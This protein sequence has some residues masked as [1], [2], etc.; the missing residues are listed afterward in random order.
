MSSY[1]RGKNGAVLGYTA[2]FAMIPELKLS[3]SVARSDGS[4]G[5]S[6]GVAF[7][8]V[9]AVATQLA[10]VYQRQQTPPSAPPSGIFGEYYG[11][12][13]AFSAPK[14]LGEKAFI[15]FFF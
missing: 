6:E 4:S 1:L 7:T 14:L 13:V 12:D 11:Q 2:Q 5:D 8:S 9:L 10:L 15:A 3:V